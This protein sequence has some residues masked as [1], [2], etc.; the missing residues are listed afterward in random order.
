[1]HRVSRSIWRDVG[2]IPSRRTRR[3]WIESLEQRLA[4]AASPLTSLLPS[5]SALANKAALVAPN[6][7]P[8]VTRAAAI[9]SGAMV[10][11][12]ST[13]SV[14][15]TDDGGAA[16]LKYTWSTTTAPSGAAPLSFSVNGTNAA[17]NTTVK[18][19]TAGAYT[20]AVTIADALGKS[21][22]SSVSVNVQPPPNAAPTIAKVAS[23]A[24][25]LISG[26]STNVSVLGAD[27]GGESNLTYSWSPATLPAGAAPPTFATNNSNAAKNTSVT[28]SSA[29]TYVLQAT[30]TD[31]AKRSVISR[32]TITVN[33]TL[34][35]IQ[36]TPAST[37]V[38]TGASQQFSAQAFDQFNKLIAAQKTFVW[39]T[40][41]GTISSTGLFK[42]PSSAGTATVRAT[43]SLVSGSAT[44]NITN[45]T[46]A[47]TPIGNG[48]LSSLVLSLY[49]DGSVGR[50]DMIQVFAAAGVDGVVD[51]SELGELRTIVSNATSLGMPSAVQV[52]AGDVVNGNVANARYQGTTLGN[53]TAGSSSSVLNKLV[54]KWFL[55]TDHPSTDGYAYAASTGTLFVNGPSYTDVN[56]GQVGDCYFIA[57]MGAIAKS[58]PA[59]ITNMIVDNG[60]KTYTVRFYANGKADYVTVDNLLPVNSSG[61][62]VYDGDGALAASTSNELW[63]PLLEKAYAQWN[64]TGKSGQNG[65]N[66]Y[67]GISGGWMADVLS[68]ALGY[69]VPSIW[70]LGGSTKQTVINAVAKNQAVTIGTFKSLYG[71]Y[72][73]HAYTIVGYNSTNDTFTLYNPW[74]SSQPGPLTWT[75]LQA[76]CDGLS[77]ADPTIAPGPTTNFTVAAAW[78]ITKGEA[79]SGDTNGDTAATS[80]ADPSASSTNIS[81]ADSNIGSASMSIDTSVTLDGFDA[82][83]DTALG[84]QLCSRTATRSRKAP[85]SSL[86][87]NPAVVDLLAS[88]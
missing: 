71:L 23:V 77:I 10:G 64:E 68:Q 58:S 56:Q 11:A 32:V 72:G 82:D 27:D 57:S 18:F 19:A 15:G 46:P 80:S 85:A 24:S 7:A 62:L 53:L 44:V 78:F 54:S 36:V 76:A 2:G 20:F 4:L 73:D 28:F 33:P 67:A 47:P 86:K 43:L 25:N 34:T 35:R 74:G 13:L 30:I 31:A 65:T 1:M 55:G 5:V 8:T 45:A 52:L 70:S 48:T 41:V 83:D 84:T 29:G 37:S 38:A 49:A 39:S 81:S 50:Q 22:T 16:N 17:K 66:S 14:L 87:L 88:R 42:A 75:Q 3:L 61:R 51:A 69:S 12:T 26:T 59:S 79:T 21:V 60:D 6:A 40:N 9:S 63:L